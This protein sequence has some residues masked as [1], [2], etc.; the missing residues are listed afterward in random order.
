MAEFIKGGGSSLFLNIIE[1]GAGNPIDEGNGYIAELPFTTE[2]F[3]PVG[4]FI[5]SNAIAGGRSRGIGCIGN[6]AGDGSF[7]TEVTKENFGIVFYSALGSYTGTANAGT[8]TPTTD[9]LPV[10]D[11][12]VRHGSSNYMIYKYES[13]R[14]NSLR[15]AFTSNGLLTASID[16]AG[17]TWSVH[18]GAV[19]TTSPQLLLSTANTILCP[20]ALAGLT[21]GGLGIMDFATGLEFT[22]ANN[23]DTDT[24]ALDAS[25]RLSVI[26]GELAVTGS[27]TLL[28][29]SDDETG[30]FT[31]LV[32]LDI[33]DELGDIVIGILSDDDAISLQNVYV[34]Q[35]VHDITDRGKVAFRIDFQAVQDGT[36]PP[37]TVNLVPGMYVP[38]T[39]VALVVP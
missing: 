10:Y 38:T 18:S 35:P 15:L 23:L 32:S 11:V 20:A 39:L 27:L 31:Q 13:Q 34:T 9:D 19:P 16:M 21:M 25:G 4:E 17:L 26:T 37:M 7:D 29:P 30:V 24:N 14:V 8:I 36:T 28:V 12:Y 33:G 1:D 3:N 22:I 6:K 2:S 5:S